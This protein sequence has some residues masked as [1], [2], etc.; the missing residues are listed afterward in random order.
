MMKR[1][2]WALSF[3]CLSS[4]S[5]GAGYQLNLQGLRQL[6]MGGSGTA[7]V[8]DASTIFY[9]PAGISSMKGIQA[10]GS[11]LF[12]MP[13]TAY[14][15]NT[16]ANYSVNTK[17]Q[18]FSPFNLYVGGPVKDGS[19][20]GVGIGVYTPFGLGLQWPSNWTGRYIVQSVSL[21]T[22]F[23]QPTVSYKFGDVLSIGA[24]FVYA[25]GAFDYKEA[26]P[27][28]NAQG[29][30]GQLN[31]H[32]NA[33]GVGYNIG[34]HVQPSEF[35]Q[36]GLTYRSQVNMDVNSGNADFTVPNSVRSSFPNSTFTTALP[37]PQVLS[38]G[39]GIRP[40]EHLTL[41]LDLNYIGWNSYDSLRFDLAQKT[42]DV[43][44]THFPRDY[45]NT[46]VTRVGA[47]YKVHSFSVMAGAFWDPTPVSSG[48]VS[49]ELPDADRFG[50]SGGLTYHPL[51]GLTILAA[52]E[53]TTTGKHLGTY[54]YYDF[55]GKYQT[56]AVTP[57][58]GVTYSF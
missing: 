38:A 40:I 32:G 30:D 11:V 13:S 48:N 15:S 47:C 54:N 7:W 28:Q 26:V 57:G 46:L 8:W 42:A 29:M 44:S 55:S 2:F 10:Y 23:I 27:V 1:Y 56:Q 49:P 19:K 20:L 6:A 53:A 21:Q 31:L 12:V 14:A 39:I 37:L 50:I 34:V 9:N 33:N 36:I 4:A 35:I 43:H 25:F 51:P 3:A 16:I 22:T 52:I 5:Y 41:Q 18:T 58:V 45:H 24:G 17:Q